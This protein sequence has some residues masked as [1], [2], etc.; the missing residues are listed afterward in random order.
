[1]PTVTSGRKPLKATAETD[2]FN[3]EVGTTRVTIL[4]RLKTGD[5][6]N[7]EG[8]ASKYTASASGRHVT[9][10]S[11]TQ[12][13]KFQLDSAADSAS[14]R[15]LDGDLTAKFA[16]KG[17]ASLG[18]QKL[19]RNAAV[20]DVTNLGESNS[21]AAIYTGTGN[22]GATGTGGSPSTALGSTFTLTASKDNIVG[23]EKSDSFNALISNTDFIKTTVEDTDSIFGGS[24]ADSDVFNLFTD[25]DVTQKPTI[26]GVET[27]DV[28]LN[29]ATSR[30][31]G[32]VTKSTDFDFAADNIA[33]GTKITFDNLATMTAVN[34]VVITGDKGGTR[35][36]SETFS[37]VA[38]DIASTA[39]TFNLKAVGTTGTPAS[40]KLSAAATEITVIAAGH[41]KYDAATA[42]GLLNI[43]V[44]KSVD[45][46][47]PKAVSAV[48]KAGGD[49]TIS[50]LS[51]AS[52][53]VLETTDGKISS[54]A[55]K[56]AAATSVRVT[57]TKDVT[58]ET[59]AATDL[60][61]SSKGTAKITETDAKLVTVNAS[62]NG[63]KMTLDLSGLHASSVLSTINTSGAKDIA[64]VLDP[65]KS[66][67]LT[68]ISKAN[69]GTLNAKLTT[70]EGDIDLS[71]VT[72][73]SLELA[74]DNKGKRLTVDSN[75]TIIISTSQTLATEVLVP[76]SSTKPNTVNIKLDDDTR[77][78][79]AVDLTSIK[80]GNLKKVTIDASIDKTSGGAAQASAFTKIEL[81]NG[82]DSTDLDLITGSNGA[83]IGAI[84]L[85][86]SNKLTITGSGDIKGFA[87]A[88]T[89]LEVDASTV[90][91][92]VS[93]DLASDKLSILRS[94]A[95]KDL[96][97]ISN[98]SRDF[99]V[100]TGAG[101]DSIEIKAAAANLGSYVIDGGDGIDTLALKSAI[102]LGA[103]TGKTVTISG[104]EN[105]TYDTTATGIQ[106][107]DS[108]LLS[109]KAYSLKDASSGQTGSITVNVVT[110]ATSID[111]STLTVAFA[112][113][114]NVADDTFKVDAGNS[115]K[116]VTFKGANIAKNEFIGGEVKVTATGGQYDDKFLVGSGMG[117]FTGGKG[118]D[119]FNVSM[120]VEASASKF[121]IITDF[122]V[123]AGA[124][125][126]AVDKLTGTG[127][128]N[129]VTAATGW[130]VSNGVME[131]SGATLPDFVTAAAVQNKETAS[132][133]VYAGNLYVYST[134]AKDTDATD[135]AMVE[136]VGIGRSGVGIETTL[137]GVGF[138]MV[139]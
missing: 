26:K 43:T 49:I 54:G 20:I 89:A 88:I 123:N 44:A 51:A 101:D 60:T 132:A 76:K 72:L 25:G 90:S 48:I 2:I 50:D 62:G 66:L 103:A 130:T 15:F 14:V 119:E 135:D 23:T 84:A 110:T 86:G 19:S 115:T 13:I 41:L 98:A 31:A 102:E 116:L 57:A 47:S 136:L 53:V 70:K 99:T 39:G 71:M 105:L 120:A 18:G 83:T 1:M 96:I 139:A 85:T 97:T 35:E 118:K 5:I 94:G 61:I 77:T 67:K 138:V 8:L 106:A 122:E 78:S 10:K 107:I 100:N 79:T 113:K 108:N 126:A 22:S 7:V 73:D 131:K 64:V 55:G 121:V 52:I 104:I 124:T 37:S 42:D 59:A 93:L 133:F 33:R 56:L 17:G 129:I 91:G 28:K 63:D 3:I 24:V 46:T 69:E 65:S 117:T 137:K 127:A 74:V 80:F 16:T 32:G 34:A 58:I 30:G 12:T 95:G 111:L 11:D 125:V 6:I 114:S 82:N 75:Q 134:G 9:L 81:S 4:G 36:F 40:L 109:E 128:K 21:S 87:D 112:N 92:A 68:T 45:V 29:S 27:V 38:S